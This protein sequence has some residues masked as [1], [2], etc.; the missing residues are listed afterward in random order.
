MFLSNSVTIVIPMLI[1]F[2]YRPQ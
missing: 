2:F 1:P